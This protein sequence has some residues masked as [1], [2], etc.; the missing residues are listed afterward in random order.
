MRNEIYLKKIIYFVTIKQDIMIL[1]GS[2]DVFFALDDL[3]QW[4]FLF[5]D[6]VQNK[7]NYLFLALGFFGFAYWMNVQRKENAKA[8]NDPNQ[9]K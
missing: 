1:G 9:I 8:A 7:L 6:W 2:S 4:C 5:Y 3:F